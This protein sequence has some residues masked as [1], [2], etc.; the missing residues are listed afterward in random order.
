MLFSISAVSTVKVSKNHKNGTNCSRFCP[1][2]KRT[3]P[4]RRGIAGEADG[5]TPQN[6]SSLQGSSVGASR[7]H[8]I[9]LEDR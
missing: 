8:R 9:P 1:P 2:P 6:P 5:K 4:A 3:D 7:H